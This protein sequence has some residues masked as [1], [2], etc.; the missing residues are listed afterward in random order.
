MSRN[1]RDFMRTDFTVHIYVNQLP[2]K[3]KTS[4]P[5]RTK[6]NPDLYKSDYTMHSFQAKFSRPLKK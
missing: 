2:I 6:Q 5:L 4:K 3:T 1:N